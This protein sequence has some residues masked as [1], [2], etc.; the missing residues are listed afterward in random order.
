MQIHTA[1]KRGESSLA[2]KDPIAFYNN[3]S[4][5][6]ILQASGEEVEL[7]PQPGSLKSKQS[8]IHSLQN[9]AEVN[10]NCDKALSELR[11]L[12]DPIAPAEIVFLNTNSDLLSYEE[13]FSQNDIRIELYQRVFRFSVKEHP[14]E[15]DFCR[16]MQGAYA[17]MI[18]DLT[19]RGWTPCVVTQMVQQLKVHQTIDVLLQA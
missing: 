8:S 4:N 6:Q 5:F 10:T 1:N 3:N 19:Q 18:T 13:H 7:S 17:E 11:C 12:L 14:S 15:E 9:M 16:V 2:H